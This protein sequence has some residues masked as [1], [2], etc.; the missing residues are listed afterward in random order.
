MQ[1]LQPET[2]KSGDITSVLQQMP[3]YKVEPRCLD[4]RIHERI[5]NLYFVVV[6]AWN[7]KSSGLN[8]GHLIEFTDEPTHTTLNYC[9]FP[10]ES[11]ISHWFLAFLSVIFPSIWFWISTTSHRVSC[12]MLSEASISHG[13]SRRSLL[14]IP[15]SPWSFTHPATQQCDDPQMCWSIPLTN[16]KQS[17]QRLM[18]IT[19]GVYPTNHGLPCTWGWLGLVGIEIPMVYHTNSHR[20]SAET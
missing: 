3:W 7:V 4:T 19:L 20:F 6:S 15:F 16:T 18:I 11:M 9:W 14:C 10:I 13:I 8:M 5:L 1:W 12:F 17:W 2:A